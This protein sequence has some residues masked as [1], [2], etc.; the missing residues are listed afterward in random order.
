MIYGNIELLKLSDTDRELIY[1]GDSIE[2]KGTGG[3]M[4]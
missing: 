1:H 3:H 2:V 4:G